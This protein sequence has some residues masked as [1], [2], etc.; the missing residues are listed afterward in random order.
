MSNFSFSSLAT[1]ANRALLH[2]VAR[3]QVLI[4]KFIINLLA[5]AI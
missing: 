5:G 1:N 2:W 3:A 4:N